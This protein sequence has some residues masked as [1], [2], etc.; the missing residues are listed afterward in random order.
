MVNAAELPPPRPIGQDGERH[1]AVLFG[2]DSKHYQYQTNDMKALGDALKRLIAERPEWRVTVFDSRRTN[3]E[4]FLPLEYIIAAQPKMDSK[5]FVDGGLGSNAE[6]FGADAILV[7][8]DS[9]SMVHEAL[10]AARPVIVVRPKAYRPPRRDRRELRGLVRAG[11]V[12]Q[13]TFNTLDAKL[14]A[15]PTVVDQISRVDE[16]ADLLRSRGF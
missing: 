14:I 2:G 13:G 6:A 1:I 12:V 5:R 3:A 9:L 4:T 16:L 15:R 8:A 7:S 10:A 11:R